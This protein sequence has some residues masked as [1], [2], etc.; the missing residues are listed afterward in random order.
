MGDGTKNIVTSLDENGLKSSLPSYCCFVVTLKCIMKCRMCYIWKNTENNLS[1]LTLQEWK[2]VV[3]ALRG[4][5]DTKY[6]IILSGGEPL[7]KKDILDLIAFSAKTGYRMS[8]ETNA[9]LI[10]KEL[11]KAIRDSGLW[12]ICISLDSMD[13]YTHDSLRGKE[14]SYS[15]ATRAIEYLNKFC[16][17]VGINIQTV[18]T[19]QNLNELIK[20]AEWV[21]QDERLDYIYFQIVARPFGASAN[22]YWFRESCYD[23]LWP[24]DINKVKSI[25]DKLIKLKNV[26]SKIV[27]T[28]SQ[29]KAYMAYFEDPLD[30]AK[31]IHCT[32]GNRDININPYGDVY[33]CFSKDS[34]GNIKANAIEEIWYSQKAA[35]IR[36][37]ISKCKKYC[38][39]L[40]NC[41]FE[42]KDC[43]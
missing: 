35:Q 11:A 21:G 5:L 34:I 1:E 17:S 15:R 28:V 26:N 3:K 4:F 10:D 22:D 42:E 24:Q 33:L 12:R 18:I 14:G 6:D 8:L 20:L 29:F 25:I 2:S 9:Y 32:I 40:L 37:E 43:F 13:E 19:E 36:D 27:N 7:L 39:F 30:F 23:F 16:P 31:D 41:S 38:H